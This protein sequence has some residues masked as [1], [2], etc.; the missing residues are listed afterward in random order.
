MV[1]II[2]RAKFKFINKTLTEKY[3]LDPLEIGM[4][5]KF[6]NHEQ[7]GEAGLRDDEIKYEYYIFVKEK[8]RYVLI[9]TDEEYNNIENPNKFFIDE[10]DIGEFA[11]L[12]FEFI[13]K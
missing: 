9:Q 3:H 2:N 11:N 1:N 12:F 4:K 13:C 5:L 6:T 8:K 7:N 10:F